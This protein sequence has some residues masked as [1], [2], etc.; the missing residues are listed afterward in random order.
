LK[1]VQ[2]HGQSLEERTGLERA[3]PIWTTY[4]RLVRYDVSQ[5]RAEIDIP[6]LDDSLSRTS[7]WST[8]SK[9]ALR[10]SETRNVDSLWWADRAKFNALLTDLFAAAD[11][12]A[13]ATLAR[14]GVEWEVSSHQQ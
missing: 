11:H 1:K 2:A 10:S 7:L 3:S 4:E 5:L 12:T 8:Q 9:A 14:A 6:K 13:A